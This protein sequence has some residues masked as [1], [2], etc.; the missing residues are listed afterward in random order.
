MKVALLTGGSDRPYALGLLEALLQK[1]V[2]VDFVGSDEFLGAD[3]L[4]D[5]RVRFLN[6]RGDTSPRV[7]R[8]QK[9][10]R[11][12]RY[13]LSLVKFAAA[14]EAQTVHVLWANRFWLIDRVAVNVVYKALGKHLVFTAHNVNE[15]KRD[16]KDS[17]YNRLT[18]RL[19]Y[20][21]M[22]RIF[23]H[24]AQMKDQL[25]QEF[26]VAVD[27]VSVIPFGINNTFPRTNV[28]GIDARD[29]LGIAEEDRVLLVF[30]RIA[31][32]KGLEYAVDALKY[33]QNEGRPY[34]LVVAGRIEQGCDDYWRRLETAI[35]ANGLS[36]QVIK[37]IDFI[38]DD[39]V[40]LFFKA[41]D[42]LLLPYKAIFQS[43]LLFLTYSF[44]LPVIAS[45]I[46]SFRE[47]IVEGVTGF[48]CAP[49][50]AVDLADTVRKYFES[51]LYKNLEDSRSDIIA[52]G[53]AKYSWQEVAD[54]T[55]GIYTALEHKKPSGGVG[56]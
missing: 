23:V 56:V 38:P 9:V 34:R 35:E 13:Y 40:E 53:N 44:G 22:D 32:Y 50:D 14:T 54:I 48:V 26:G 7:P 10:L 52:W 16:G 5:S 51:D 31:P 15:K 33:L 39:E 19:L 8:F 25:V 24:T 47:D 17:A 42:A 21:L 49:Q 4:E 29:R 6:L 2:S 36:A 43:G 45:D 1:S 55:G 12:F 11:I 46:G 30:G 41:A 27:K 37:R 20:G 28:T 3:I 18:L